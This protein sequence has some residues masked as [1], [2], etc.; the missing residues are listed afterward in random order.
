MMPVLSP[1]GVQEIVDYG[2]YGYAMSRF[3]GVWVGLKC[4]K[5]TVESTGSID[6]S[7]DRVRPIAPQRFR[8]A[9]RRPQY[10][11]RATRSSRRRSACRTTSATPCWPVLRANRLNKIITSGGPNAKIGVIT[12]GKSYLDVRQAMDDLGIDEI[13]GE[14]LRLAAHE[15]RLH[16]ADRAA[17]SARI[18]ARA[19]FDYRRRGKALADR[20]AAARGALRLAE[21]ADLRRQEGRETANGC[22]RSPA[23]STPMTSPSRSAAAC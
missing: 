22:F 3:T 9:A 14:R 19:R 13:D 4:L 12:A 23:R 21:P 20:S 18:R 10:S 7:L 16:L 8:H 2:L 1:A 5:D 6:V 15:A 17:G 11:R